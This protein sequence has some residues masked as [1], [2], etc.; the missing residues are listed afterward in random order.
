MTFVKFPSAVTPARVTPQLV[1]ADGMLISPVSGIQQMASR[2][3]VYWRHSVEFRN[4]STNERDIVQAFLMKAQGS[5][6]WFKMPDFGGYEIDLTPTQTRVMITSQNSW[7][8]TAQQV[9]FGDVFSNTGHIWS[10]VGCE[11][12]KLN[13]DY[14]TGSHIRRI[15]VDNE[16]VF[17]QTLESKAQTNV[18]ANA[19]VNTF[20]PENYQGRAAYIQ[21]IKFWQDPESNAFGIR[22]QC[23]SK[24]AGS[25]PLY[26]MIG[27]TSCQSSGVLSVPFF[28]GFAGGCMPSIGLTDI[29]SKAG[30]NDDAGIW[31]NRHSEFRLADYYVARCALVCNSENLLTRSNDF[32]NAVWAVTNATVQSGWG[33]NDPVFDVSSGA[34]KLITDTSVNTEHWL[35]CSS[36]GLTPAGRA[37]HFTTSVYAKADEFGGLGLQVQFLDGASTIGIIRGNFNLSSG[38]LISTPTLTNCG[39]NLSSAIYDCSSG[40]YRCTLTAMVHS[41]CDSLRV[42]FDVRSLNGAGTLT[43]DGTSG[44]LLYGAQVNRHL[45]ASPYIPITDTAVVGSGNWQS[46]S[47]LWVNGL[48]ADT[49][50][51]AGTRFEVITQ[52]HEDQAG[53]YE[54]SEFKRIIYETKVNRDGTALLEFQPPLRN[55]PK[56]I[57]FHEPSLGSAN[58]SAGTV[59]NAVIFSNPE[60]RSKLVGSTIQYIEK[61]LQLTDIVFDVIEDLTE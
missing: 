50:I 6:N 5:N 39:Y 22:A 21:R 60:V 31:R 9:F 35:R 3:N 40:W 24:G 32:S 12:T 47:R 20:A 54:K 55:S 14:V 43:G 53:K 17:E 44:I 49:V 57:Q 27:D 52:Y 41:G 13:S 46:G 51:K 10:S 33:V 56:S 61:P 19:A 16:L 37:D 36:F 26:G 30:G 2:S 45:F 29:A 28:S 48:D 8:V 42:R 15:S 1:R 58:P 34:W 18:L 23:G 38:S 4:L 7:N 59:H 25:F 11:Q